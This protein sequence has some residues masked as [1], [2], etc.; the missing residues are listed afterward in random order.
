MNKRN[1][2]IIL[3]LENYLD[4]LLNIIAVYVSYVLACIN[5]KPTVEPN[6]TETVIWI[7]VL[8]IISG[9]T[10]QAFDIYT[11][12]TFYRISS[13]IIRTIE[14][15][16]TF[17]GLTAIVFALFAEPSQKSFLLI[18]VMITLAVSTAFLIFKRR[19]MRAIFK[20]LHEKQFILR[21]VIVAGDNTEAAKAYVNQIEKNPQ[22][23]FMV[24]GCVGNKI[25]E[26]VGCDKLGSFPD[27]EKI[28]DEHKPTDVVFA[29][30]AYDKRH[31]IRLVNICDDR[32]IKVYFLPV[33]YGFFKSSKQLEQVG[34][35]P[36]INIHTTPLDNRANAAVKRAVD[37]IGSLILI[38]L[39]S[40]IMIAAAI[41]TKITSKGPI[42]FKQKRV[43]KMG[44]PFTMLKFRSMEVNDG[45]D[46]TWTGGR[47][48]RKTRFGTFLRRTAIDELPQLFNVLMGSMSLVGPRP[49]LPKFVDEFRKDI[50][51]YMIKH[52]LKPGLTGLA[53]IKGLRG[54]TSVVDRI[55][56]DI[57]YIENWTLWL[58]FYILFMTPFRA[59]N[60]NEVYVNPAKESENESKA[61]GEP[62][63]EVSVKNTGEEVSPDSEKNEAERGLETGAENS[64][65]EDIL[66]DGTSDASV[67][68]ICSEENKDGVKRAKKILYAA[69]TFGHIEAF[70]LPYIEALRLEGNEVLTMANGEGADFNIPFEKKIFSVRNFKC[71]RTV[72]KIIESEDFDLIILNTS[73]A[74]FH[75]RCALPKSARPRVVN[76]AHGYLFSSQKP[77]GI[78]GKIKNFALLSAE[79]FL[80]GKTDAVI[81]MNREDYEIAK[82][83]KLA[84][85]ITETLG[86][87]VKRKDAEVSREDIRREISGEEQRLVLLF[88]GEL[89]DRKN[90]EYLIEKMPEVLEKEPKAE[91]WLVGEGDKR[92]SLELLAEGLGVSHRV[93]L[94]GR[95]NNV[96]DYLRAADIYVSAS[97]SEGLP[98]N[99]VEALGAGL[100]V[101]ASSVKGQIDILED[102]AG[103]LFSP[104]DSRAYINALC[105]AIAEGVSPKAEETF[106]KYSF[107]KVFTDTFE[108]IKKAGEI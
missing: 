27:F 33:T 24:L 42:L 108:K 73:L 32:C 14:A 11:R 64:D 88:V 3:I 22:Y 48:T 59:F 80:A 36:V 19:I 85:E 37:I 105:E 51:L 2:G 16:I 93:K 1:R 39:T 89:S 86:M 90:S 58:D 29:I 4:M 25:G 46:T 74:A 57:D 6:S 72:K 84:P 104:A 100:P 49:E 95:K 21:K 23:G 52:Y 13:S 38:I 98:F 61:D 62:G 102:G 76:I 97:K 8:T 96:F 50:P 56:E 71:Q 79:K 68:E 70:H 91:L 101:V 34:N 44:K 77:L 30:D 20:A 99:I 81:T 107:E 40:P 10:Y 53:Q 82:T 92:E 18:W 83:H 15:N 55:H 67:S 28:L 41:G 60:K 87:G 94:L 69:S 17:F 7:L 12:H 43:G 5:M 45:S 66:R 65:S 106:V 54:D 26:E 47:D 103:K 75:I 9:F 63:E 35:L 78:K 31:L